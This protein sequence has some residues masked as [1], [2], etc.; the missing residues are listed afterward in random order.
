MASLNF[1]QPKAQTGKQ[2]L[3]SDLHL[4]ITENTITSASNT[5]LD[6]KVDYDLQAIKNSLYNLFN[7]KKGQRPL[8]PDFGVSLEQYLFEPVSR[9]VAYRIGQELEE[10]LK[11]DD[12]IVATR[13]NV[14]ILESEDGYRVELALFIPALSINTIVYASI[15]ADAGFNIV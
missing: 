14:F 4:D 3:Y 15:S 13:I 5:K 1:I 8:Y 10:G 9:Q 7:T 12:R 2:Y 6:I 11:A